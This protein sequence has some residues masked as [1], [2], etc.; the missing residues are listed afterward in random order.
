MEKDKSSFASVIKIP[1]FRYIW[2][3]QFFC[4]VAYNTLN[5][6]LVIWVY[7]LTNSNFA[8]S[9]IILCVYL[10]SLLFG[11]FGG[12]L[13]DIV[14]KKKILLYTAFFYA[15]AYLLF[16]P[17]RKFYPLLV[18]NTFFL[19]SI[20]QFFM[21]AESSSI[22][23]LVNKKQLFFSN[24][25]FSLTLYIALL[26]GFSSAGVIL[27]KL[28]V[29]SIFLLGFIFQLLG[30]VMVSQLPPL[31]SRQ[32]SL[33]SKKFLK[34]F[35]K[36]GSVFHGLIIR[37]VLQL[38]RWETQETLAYIKGKVNLSVAIGLLAGMQ[39]VIGTLAVLV[40]SYLERVLRIHATDASYF[41][42]MPL[43]SGMILGAFFVGRFGG[44]IP[45]RFIVT[46]AIITAGLVFLLIGL[47]PLIA[48]LLAFVEL[49]AYHIPRLRYFF[50]V[51]SLSSWFAFG[52]FILG[53][54]SVSV[55]I[56]SQTVVQEATTDKV[57]GK[58]M[59]ILVVLMNCSSAIPVLVSGALADL[60]GVAPV[61]TILGITISLV[62]LIA[63]KPHL[64]IKQAKLPFRIKEFL[65]LGH[66]QGA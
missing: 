49:P 28:G 23:I 4:Q 29:V 48:K 2:L 52:A 21:P 20:S 17:A 19:N 47:T 10:P 39:G 53:L 42:M 32:L 59:S 57:R 9:I 27:N 56:P 15:L 38:A 18:L 44:K 54:C 43:G 30:L 60:I 16:I 61:F 25:L 6:A 45:R 37:D 34:D 12:L 24:S 40:P 7:K 3:N 51:P 13:A 36:Q 11:V 31:K 64:F 33:H 50:K 35:R 46:P 63:L 5:F 55:V 66:W 1:G 58:I 8:V 14:D 41:L 62:G 22:P 26:I 65:G